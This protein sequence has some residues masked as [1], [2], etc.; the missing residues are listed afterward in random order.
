MPDFDRPVVAVL[1]LPLD[2]IDEDAALGTLCEAAATGRRLLM[3]TPNLNI[4][5][6]C[7]TDAT[8]RASVLKS[9]LSVADGSPLV[10]AA[11]LLGAPLPGRVAGSSL[12]EHLMRQHAHRFSVFFLGG[13]RGAGDVAR[14]R[15]NASGTPGMRCVGALDPGKGDVE[16]MSREEILAAVNESGADFLVLA[17]GAKKGQAW[18]LRNKDRLVPPVMAYLGAVINFTAGTVQRA[19]PWMQDA[20]LEWLWRIRQEAHLWRRY[21]DDGLALGQ[22]LLT[23]VLPGGLRFRLQ[24]PPAE[25][26]AAASAYEDGEGRLHLS[27][28]WGAANVRRLQEPFAKLAASGRPARVDL[29]DVSYLDPAAIGLLMLLEG[30]GSPLELTGVS[31]GLRR[32]FEACCADYLLETSPA[33]EL[34]PLAAR[35]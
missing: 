27:G 12:F 21:R 18:L 23:R 24:R 17:I 29:G 16:E 2:A 26:F 4:A 9:D 11:W 10:W 5:I 14:E 35:G 25:A 33:A 3:T 15:L 30:A 19:P 13:E 8:L 7:L 34:T 6:A 22:L 31:A 28:P 1:G 20:G 32:H